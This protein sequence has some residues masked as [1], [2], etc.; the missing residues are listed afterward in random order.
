M[1]EYRI[2]KIIKFCYGHRLLNYDGKSKNLHGHNAYVEIDVA[3]KSLDG[4]GMVASFG[5][6]KEA[7]ETWVQDNFDHQVI[8]ID[9]DPIGHP[10]EDLGQMVNMLTVNPTSENLAKILFMVTQDMGFDVSEVR[11]WETPTSCASYSGGN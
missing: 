5:S 11:F 9:S 3:S 10:L 8:L 1:A 2:T 4:R 7:I 6:L